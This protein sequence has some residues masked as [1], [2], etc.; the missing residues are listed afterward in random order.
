MYAAGL[1]TTFEG[2]QNFVDCIALMERRSSSVCD[3]EE[4]SKTGNVRRVLWKI[5]SSLA[6]FKSPVNA[7]FAYSFCLSCHPFSIYSIKYILFLLPSH[8]SIW[9]TV[10]P[11]SSSALSVCHVHHCLQLNETERR[12]SLLCNANISVCHCTNFSGNTVLAVK[13]RSKIST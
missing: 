11:P 7:T 2:F 13:L 8:C 12:E 4:S 3:E 9:Q 1:S 6:T 10:L 5:P